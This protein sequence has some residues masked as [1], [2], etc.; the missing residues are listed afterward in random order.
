MVKELNSRQLDLAGTSSETN[1]RHSMQSVRMKFGALAMLSLLIL[2]LALTVNIYATQHPQSGWSSFSRDAPS[3]H[4]GPPNSP[5][6][7]PEEAS[8]FHRHAQG[9]RDAHARHRG[10]LHRYLFNAAPSHT[11]TTAASSPSY[12]SEVSNGHFHRHHRN[13]ILQAENG[14][15]PYEQSGGMWQQQRHPEPLIRRGH[16]KHVIAPSTLQKRGSSSTTAPNTDIHTDTPTVP[17]NSLHSMSHASLAAKQRTQAQ[18]ERYPASQKQPQ[19]RRNLLSYSAYE[20]KEHPISSTGLTF[21]TL[22]T[23]FTM[24]ILLRLGW[25]VVWRHDV[26]GFRL[27]VGVWGLL[28]SDY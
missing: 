20:R 3:V 11:A 19:S 6:E 25:V 17:K 9:N 10:I 26:L 14:R 27:L 5:E 15:E 8:S 7:T 24:G 28:S 1:R 13:A 2:G 23:L 4:I 18:A 12:A 21:L 16:H 22:G